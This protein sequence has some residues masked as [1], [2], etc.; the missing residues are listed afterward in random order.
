MASTPTVKAAY[1]PSWASDIPLSTI[2]TS[3]FTH[4]YY[5]FLMP[6]NNSY[7]LEI[8]DPRS[9]SNFTNTL[10]HKNP[11]AKALFA[12]GGASSDPSIYARMASDAITRQTFVKSCIDVARNFGFDGMDLDWE[13]PQ[14]PQE[15]ENLGLLFS[16]LRHAI[17]EEA[18]DTNRGPWLLTAAVYF[19][20][21]FTWGVH[22][23]FPVGSITQNLD[24]INVMCYDY[25]GSWD[26]SR[27]GAHA[28][29]NDPNGN[30]STSFAINSWIIAGVPSNKV[31][32]GLALYGKTWKLRDP[33]LHRIG[34]P[35]VAV[36]PGEDGVLTFSQVLEFN[37]RNGANV[38]HD[39][40]TVSVYSFAGSTW[41]GYDDDESIAT[42][43][44][45]AKGLGLRGYFFWALGSDSNWR[46]CRRAS[47]EWIR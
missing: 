23:R 38:V 36:G 7:Q 15:M 33:N 40:N 35:A 9:L 3:L 37:S 43:I 31:V 20:V 30:L 22:R 28:A 26:T 12:V 21:E 24:W 41:I 8:P 45:Y 13:F 34:S 14:N 29:L 46:I 39:H 2:E 10:H 32:M 27:T 18:R 19:N 4:I 25:H 11:P 47:T 1:W 16:E 17:M 5:A 6:S 44:R 42:K